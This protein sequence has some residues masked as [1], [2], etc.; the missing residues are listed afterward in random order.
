M[1]FIEFV[2]LGQR[3]ELPHVEAVSHSMVRVKVYG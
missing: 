2:G 3:R 1:E